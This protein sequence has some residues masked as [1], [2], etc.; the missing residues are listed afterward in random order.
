M[1]RISLLLSAVAAFHDC[2]Q[3]KSVL[4]L[5]PTRR[6]STNRG[7]AAPGPPAGCQGGLCV[8]M[9]GGP[10]EGGPSHYVVGN[11]TTGFTSVSST[12]TV[13]LYPK[14]QDGITYFRE[15]G[16]PL[17]PS[18]SRAGTILSWTS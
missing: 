12:M 13:P 7:A 4:R 9:R 11:A 18:P 6:S 15:S 14:K 10:H 2:V 8:G 17:P 1:L 16:A 5:P 3:P